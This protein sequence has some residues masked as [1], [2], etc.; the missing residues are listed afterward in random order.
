MIQSTDKTNYL[1]NL[2]KMGDIIWVHSR[3]TADVE[4]GLKSMNK[5]A[6]TMS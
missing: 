4:I 1:K 3:R 5:T 2:M 6:N